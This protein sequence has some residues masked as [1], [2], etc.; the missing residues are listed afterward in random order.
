[1]QERTTLSGPMFSLLCHIM[2]LFLSTHEEIG[3]IFFF[4]ETDTSLI[5]LHKINNGSV[6]LISQ[7]FFI[8]GF[9]SSR[10]S[11]N[12]HYQHS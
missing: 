12:K 3:F 10:Q 11:L 9:F 4:L 6:I 2:F 5:A 7:F 8:H 1:M